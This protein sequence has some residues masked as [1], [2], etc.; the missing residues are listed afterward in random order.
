MRV[1]TSTT[2][3]F[4]LFPV[5]LTGPVLQS[6]K[7]QALRA[8]LTIACPLVHTHCNDPSMSSVAWVRHFIRPNDT[9]RPEKC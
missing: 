1:H 3:H 4:L 9:L 8:F 6:C 7:A 2:N 5:V